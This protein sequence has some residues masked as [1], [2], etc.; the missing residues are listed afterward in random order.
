MSARPFVVWGKTYRVKGIPHLFSY[1]TGF[2][3]VVHRFINLMTI[4]DAFWILVGLV[5]EYPRLWCL[6]KSSMVDEAKSHY[7]YEMTVMRAVLEINFPEVAHKLYQLGISVESLIYD[8]MTSLYSD[9]FHSECLL[10]I[11][12]QMIF[13]FNTSQKKRGIWLILA[14][15]ILVIAMKQKAIVDARTVKEVFEAYSDGSCI[16]YNPNTLIGMLNSI[17]DDIFVL[18]G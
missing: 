12:D 7:R 11:W 3:K 16:N 18:G 9:Y 4:E 17:I 2:L 5:K 15:S 1:P 6:K 10:R 13:N 8:S 14:P